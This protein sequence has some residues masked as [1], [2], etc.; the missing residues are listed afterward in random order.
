ME[1]KEIISLAGDLASGKGTVSK[2]ICEKLDFTT[3][4]LVAF[5]IMRFLFRHH[6]LF[7]SL[8]FKYYK[9]VSCYSKDLG[10]L[11][12]LREE[13]SSGIGLIVIK[14]NKCSKINI[15]ILPRFVYLYLFIISFATSSGFIFVVSITKS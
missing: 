1:K 10:K 6:E 7:N 11:R 2:I 8:L 15:E 3:N 13:N 14:V 9:N 5:E 12:N 4:K